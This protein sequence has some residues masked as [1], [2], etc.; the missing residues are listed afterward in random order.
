[1]RIGNPAIWRTIN[2]PF[3]SA[4]LAKDREAQSSGWRVSNG[5]RMEWSEPP[6]RPMAKMPSL[7]QLCCDCQ[8]ERERKVRT[9]RRYQESDYQ[10]CEL[11]W[12]HAEEPS[13]H[14]RV[15]S[16][17]NETSSRPEGP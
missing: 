16:S 15:G 17:G 7:I 14:G 3:T 10:G 9:Q 2:P 5:Q 1:M 8:Q 12:V 4:Q 13:S 6:F 11:G